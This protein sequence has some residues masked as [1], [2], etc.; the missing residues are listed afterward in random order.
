[1][2]YKHGVFVYE[3][4]TSI[5]PPVQVDSAVQ[6]AIGL[7]PV[8]LGSAENP[9]APQLAYSY[10]EAV[11]KVGISKSLMTFALSQVIRASFVIYNVSP[12]VLINVLDPSKHTK[13]VSPVSCPIL[14]GKAVVEQEGILIDSLTVTS[15]D[16]QG[17]YAVGEDFTVGF[18]DDGFLELTILKTGKIPTGTASLR[19]GFKQLDP[20]KVKT[21]DILAGI[22]KIREVYPRFGLIPGLLLCPGW[23]HK[24]EVLSA[25]TAMCENLNGAFR[26]M[27]LP[28][29]DTLAAPEYETV[30][31]EKNGNG[32][33]SK[34]N[35]VLWPC[36]RNGEDV[37]HYSTIA[38]AHIAWTDYENMGV[39]YVSPSNKDLRISG[40]CDQNGAEIILDKEQADYLNGQGICTAINLNG[41]KFWGNRTGAYPGSTDPKDTFIPIRRFFSW[42]ANTFILTYYQKVDDP[43]NR[44]LIDSVV[45]SENLRAN[46]FKARQQIADARIEYRSADNPLTDLLNGHIMFRQKL[47]ALPPAEAIMETLEFDPNGLG[48]ALSLGG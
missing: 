44:R 18:D 7:A 46:G 1:M 17:T 16:S 26:C 13:S 28:D 9:L 30:L 48:E 21:A 22:A 43:M 27:A 2:A 8:N 38:G 47:A 11:K 5:T 29:I 20:S 33:T 35:T 45:D 24:P 12:I 14:S 34:H 37:Y 39:P 41:W 3:S 42:W 40:I 10:D 6:V 4:P 19:V 32:V 23:S 25:M 31:A 36:C 15:E